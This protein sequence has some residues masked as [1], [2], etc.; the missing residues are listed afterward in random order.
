[1]LA[2]AEIH[3]GVAATILPLAQ[4]HPGIQEEKQF[5]VIFFFEGG[6]RTEIKIKNGNI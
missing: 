3:E 1:M 6:V 2:V 4:V 5:V